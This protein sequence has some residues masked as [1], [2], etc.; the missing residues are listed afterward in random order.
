M[1]SQQR[2]SLVNGR[3]TLEQ[4][5]GGGGMGTVYRAYDRLTGKAV[6]L[7]RVKLADD[8]AEGTTVDYRAM[9]TLFE[10]LA[11][12]F[13]VLAS[14]RHPHIIDVLDYGFDDTRQPYFTMSLVPGAAPFVQ[15]VR[16]QSQEQQMRLLLQLLQA[17]D[18]LHIRGLL[19]RDLKPDN[20]LVTGEQHV[21]VLDF[22]LATLHEQARTDEIAGTILY[23]APELFQGQAPSRA[24]DLY[25]FGVMLYETLRGE[26]PFGEGRTTNL[27]LDILQ[28][29]VATDD[30]PDDMAIIVERLLAK[31]AE[32][33]YQSA[34]DV[35]IA[36]CEANEHPIPRETREIRESFLQGAPFIGHTDDLS[37]LTDALQKATQ[38]EGSGWII[39]GE[40]GVG[41]S[42]LLDELR[43][44]GYVNDVLVLQGQAEPNGLPYQMWREPLRRFLLAQ[45][46][47]D[48]QASA[49]KPIIPDLEA[50]LQRS[51]PDSAPV[52]Q[53]SFQ[54]RLNDT[55][56]ALFRDY[57]KPTLLILDDLQWAQESLPAL[58]QLS[59]MVAD[60]PLQIVATYRSDENAS[61]P[62]TLPDLQPIAL[63]R[64][65]SEDIANLSNAILG[66]EGKRDEIVSYLHEHS[67][68]NVYFML[69]IL[70]ALAEE[71][72]KLRQIS[73]IQLPKQVFAG[74]IQ[75][76]MLRRWERVPE[77]A[78][79]LLQ[80]AALI[81]RDLD[82]KLLTTLA[83]EQ[84]LA[85]WLTLCVNSAVLVGVDETWNFTHDK[86]REVIANT[87]DAAERTGQHRLIAEAIEQTYPASLD[88]AA[89]V[90]RH[91]GLADDPVREYPYLR[92]ALTHHLQIG[93]AQDA[94]E[95]SRRALEILSAAVSDPD[96]Q[97]DAR[98]DLLI[99]RTQA[100]KY[101]SQLEE[102][103][104]TLED[105]A[106]IA[107]HASHLAR[108]ALERSDIAHLRGEQDDAITLGE[109]GLAQYRNLNDSQGTA[110]MLRHLGAVTLMK[111]DTERATAYLEESLAMAQTLDDPSLIAGIYNNLSVIKRR[112]GDPQTA[113]EHLAQARIRWEATGEQRKLLQVLINLGNIHAVSDEFPEAEAIYKQALVIAERI[114][115]QHL[116]GHAVNN[117][118]M[119]AMLTEQFEA[120]SH[121]F[122]RTLENARKIGAQ[123]SI[124][125]ALTNLGHT[126]SYQQDH[127][128]AGVYFREAIETAQAVQAVPVMLEALVG[129][130]EIIEDTAMSRRWLQSLQQHPAASNSIRTQAQTAL[131]TLQHAEKLAPENTDDAHTE[132][133]LTL[134]EIVQ[135]ALNT[136][137]PG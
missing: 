124:A 104:S 137:H 94:L 106:A 53:K 52:D 92:R 65:S 46:I 87:L 110:I 121:Y 55:I 29:T 40:T 3:Y 103:Q 83:A 119:V 18:Y 14:L 22:G 7:K 74:G 62:E 35:I 112:Q 15:A 82:L 6:A 75:Q 48:A 9:T 130:A 27:I 116:G 98:T 81:G 135:Q 129:L 101:L 91:W 64:L 66:E 23:M 80:T 56:V 69:E 19:H 102:A 38:G 8:A 42:R 45:E 41:K 34:E 76:V 60:L 93:A 131:E 25:A 132:A 30:L 113:K 111:G 88:Q 20:A 2:S 28:K 84:D 126:A 77:E 85:N 90:A 5:L 39:G 125:N 10:T 54:Q 71:S 63:S 72:G 123:Q 33:R 96:T 115:D 89:E 37:T 114:G 68:G 61:L 49:L 133:A 128:L 70:R 57:Q 11:H 108:I 97:R 79:G 43:I 21:K 44:K 95:L 117:L 59:G 99:Q 51:I 1:E 12:E 24:S 100:Y 4:E 17:I 13:Q 120:A 47:S 58:Q 107:I 50:L 73:T 78:R 26:H 32:D 109:V 122:Q 105:A 127:S 136:W 31:T 118:G 134:E 67:E 36:L 86:L 16:T